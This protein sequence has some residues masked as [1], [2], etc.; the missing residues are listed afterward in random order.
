MARDPLAALARL[1]GLETVRAK[2]RLGECRSGRT[3]PRPSSALR[4]AA[5]LPAEHAAGRRRLAAWLPRGLAERDRAALAQDQAATRRRDG[6]G[7]A[8]RC[9]AAERAVELLRDR[10]AA[11]ARPA[12]AAPRPRRVLDEAAQRGRPAE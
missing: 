3:R 5:A 6:P 9:R 1:R 12:G 8:G 4:A 11:E 10:R 7:G 2:R